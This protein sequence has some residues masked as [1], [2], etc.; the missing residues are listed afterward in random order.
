MTALMV[1]GPHDGQ[2]VKDSPLYLGYNWLRFSENFKTLRD[3]Y[4][5]RGA[6]VNGRAI[7]DYRASVE[8]TRE[9]SL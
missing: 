6:P 1:G 4:D 3:E 8:L 9:I 5:L 7:Y 2:E